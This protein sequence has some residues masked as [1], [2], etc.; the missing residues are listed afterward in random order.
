MHG[1]NKKYTNKYNDKKS[2]VKEKL[3]RFIT[4]TKSLKGDP[5]YIAKGMAIGVFISVT[6]T[7]PFHTVTAIF[8]SFILKGS[9]LAAATGVWACNPLTLPFFY[10]G[11]YKV[12][13]Y[14]FGL[15][16]PFDPSYENLTELVK[17]GVELTL[18]MIT[19]GVIIGIPIG[20]IAY[21]ITLK[22]FIGIRAR[23]KGDRN[24]T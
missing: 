15:S 23:Q 22:I 18:A 10:Y 2:S 6:P 21:F 13:T 24:I 16:A 12:G 14:L 9:K 5:H 4:Q 17:I 20:M 11:S 19:G 7:I 8:L 3:E 1:I